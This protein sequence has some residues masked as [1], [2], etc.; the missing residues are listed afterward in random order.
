MSPERPGAA[1]GDI[2]KGSSVRRQHAIT[3]ALQ[4]GWPVLLK[5]LCELRHGRV[6]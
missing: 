4:I 2:H 6:F 5:D 3:K 1:A